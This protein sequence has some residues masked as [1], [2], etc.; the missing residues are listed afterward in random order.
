MKNTYYVGCDISAKWLD[1]AVVSDPKAKPIYAD[2]FDN[3]MEGIEGMLAELA[4][5]Q[6]NCTL[7]W[8]CMEHTGHYGVLLC[9]L[10]QQHE[11]SYSVIPALEIKKSG[12]ITRGKSDRVDALRI[13]RYGIVNSHKLSPFELPGQSILKLKELITYRSLLVDQRTQLSNTKKSREK[14]SILIK[15]KDI[16]D[17]ID[18]LLRELEQ[19]IKKLE[20][21]ILTTVNDDEEIKKNF[22]LVKSVKG[23]GL[24]STVLFIVFTQNFT[25]F[26]DARKFSCY[27]G[28]A[29]FEHSSGLKSGKTRVSTLANKTMKTVL[30]N[31]AN[32]AITHDKEMREYYV[33]KRAEGKHHKSVVNAVACKLIYR[34]FAVVKRGTEFVQLAA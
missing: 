23:I 1:I 9:Y 28:T 7:S 14:L 25:T 2:R 21:L 33:R 10:L 15:N 11:W 5:N 4:N 18:H 26:N 6:I 30:N 22:E 31:G 32:S 34:V 19:S 3:T 16:L 12:G 27:C 20:A 29:P 17:D 8:F 24:I 13:A